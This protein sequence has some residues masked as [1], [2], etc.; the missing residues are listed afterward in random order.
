[1]GAPQF[2]AERF[3]F[4]KPVSIDRE[5]GIV[6]GVRI[7][8]VESR[9]DR[10]YPEAVLARDA[11]VYSELPVNVGHHYNPSTML[12]VEVPPADRFG[13]LSKVV[14]FADGGLTAEHLKFNP[15]HP[16]AEPFIWA[17]E[18]DPSLYSFSPLHRVK[19]LPQ[20][21]AKG[22]L[23]AESILEGASVDIVSDGG[24][25]S[26]IFE[27]RTWVGEM[28]DAE[29]IAGELE[30]DGAWIAFLTDLFAK[31]KGLAQAT[32]DTIAAL[33]AS[34]MAGST[35]AAVPADGTD[36]AAAAP[37][38]EALRR[39][40]PVGKWA[41]NRIDRAF[42]AE[43]AKKRETWAAEFIKSAAVPESLVTP[44]FASLV[45]E[46]YGNEARAKELCDDRKKLSVPA[47]GTKPQTTDRAG[48]KSI[49]DLVDGYAAG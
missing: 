19:W 42:V 24:T 18:N 4:G 15:K 14:T 32:K 22:R 9:N 45:A 7:V 31:M 20:R 3:S 46:S 28:V 11:K 44:T 41:A 43:S 23:V 5:K 17:C 8:N 6:T 29:K 25:T 12:P 34:A 16:F 1:M 30:T 36:P 40:G 39:M 33:V 27:S 48:Q 26:S 37:A 13:R 10:V 21:D 35:E 49:K 47:G 38:M 2:V